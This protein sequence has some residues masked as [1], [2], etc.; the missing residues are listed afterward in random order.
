MTVIRRPFSDYIHPPP[1]QNHSAPVYVKPMAP[2]PRMHPCKLAGGMPCD[3][4]LEGTLLSIR[5][6]LFMHGHKH[7][8]TEL[9]QCPWTGCSD[10]LRWM[11][12]PRH[13]RSIHLG[14]RMVCPN[15]KRSFTRA[16]GLA[17]HV[18]SKNCS[19]V[20]GFKSLYFK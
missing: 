4:P 13:I 17:K 5:R 6:H 10:M 12:L 3:R 2:A 14:V 20:S 15:C 1:V 19:F 18:A 9:V 11:N 16:L 8:G 7:R